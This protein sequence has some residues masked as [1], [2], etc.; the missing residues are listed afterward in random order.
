MGGLPYPQKFPKILAQL[1]FTWG[2]VGRMFKSAKRQMEGLGSLGRKQ[3]GTVTLKADGTLWKWNFNRYGYG[4]RPRPLNLSAA[5]ATR[6]GTHS[7]WV[8][9]GQM[10]GGMFRSAADGNLWLWQSERPD[11]YRGD[12]PPLLAPTRQPQ[13][14]RQHLWQGGLM[15]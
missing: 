13:L 11:Y 14:P 2:F 3:L 15:L 10:M 6:L 4:N 5:S 12:I 9:V 8:A 1:N 7:D